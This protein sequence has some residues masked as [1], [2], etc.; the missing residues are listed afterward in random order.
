M[1][2][3]DAIHE[4]IAA[5]E[6][7]GVRPVEAIEQRLMSG[8]LIRFRCEGDGRG[9]QNGWAKIYLDERPAG[10]FGNYRLGIDRKWKSGADYA[11]LSRE[12]REKLQ[13]EWAEA[14]E[15]RRKEQERSESEA[16]VEALEM[17]QR[18]QP[19]SS[20][21]PYVVK[22]RL[23]PSPLRQIG[24]KLLVP[25]VDSTGKLWNLQR[26]AG[27]G[28]K[29]FLRGGRVD[30]LFHLI[31]YNVTDNGKW[32]IGEGYSTM[33]AVHR[34]TGHPCIVTFSSKNMMTVARIW[35]SARPDLNY[36]VCADDDPHLVDHPQIRK[37]LGVVTA[38]AVAEEIGAKVA[39]PRPGRAAA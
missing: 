3:L 22:K 37:N 27:D 18:A 15:A 1:S 32:C 7:E 30:G 39:L 21:H 10:A 12:E 28:T 16:A 26:I 17:W 23:D 11:P 31:A 38:K 13:R 24:D 19:A 9:R 5:M 14:K 20:E 25:M 2:A 33:A 35:N 6:M 8:E 29:R 34:S 4:L 36:I